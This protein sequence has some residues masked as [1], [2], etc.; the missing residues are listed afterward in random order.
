M[1]IQERVLEQVKALGEAELLQLEQ[2]LQDLHK[3]PLSPEDKT[4]LWRPLIGMLDDPDD[5]A[6][7]EEATARRP[8]FANRTL[9]LD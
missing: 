3:E 7:F 4:A 8:L 6:A 5:L 1:T 2:T 9:E